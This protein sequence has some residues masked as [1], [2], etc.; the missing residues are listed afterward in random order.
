[1]KYKTPK[2]TA[3]KGPCMRVNIFAF[4]E[5]TELHN[6]K[7]TKATTAIIVGPRLIPLIAFKIPEKKV[8]PST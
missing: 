6:N 7:I 4:F 8:S 1:M 5:R 2:T 3:T